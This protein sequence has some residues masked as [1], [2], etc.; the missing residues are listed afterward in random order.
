[1]EGNLLSCRHDIRKLTWKGYPAIRIASSTI[2][3][4]ALGGGMI[5]MVKD[6][7]I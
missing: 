1:M 3:Q 4:L 5:E 6:V 7:V 2:V